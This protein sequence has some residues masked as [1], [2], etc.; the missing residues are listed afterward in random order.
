MP[1]SIERSVLFCVDDKSKVDIGEPGSAV[2]TGVRGKKSIVPVS[3]T[4]SAL[5]HDMQSKLSLTP[6]VALKVG[7]PE[8][9]EESFYRGNVTVKYKDSVFQPSTPFRHAVEMEQILTKG[10]A[11]DAVPPIL[12][13]FSD[14]GPDHRITYHSVKLALIVLFKK[15]NLDM[16]IAGRSAPG[17][18]WLNPA[19]RIMSILNLALQNAAL[20]RAECRPEFE[21]TLNGA[22]SMA[23]IRKNAERV[24][25]LKA[26]WVQSASPVIELLEE[27]TNRLSLQSKRFECQPA[28][29]DDEVKQFEE[30][31][32]ALIDEDITLGQY[33]EKNVKAKAAY[34]QFLADHCR[35]RH[36][37]FQ[38]RKCGNEACCR[39]PQ[40]YK[41]G[42]AICT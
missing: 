13:I 22:N 29:S 24:E 11:N 25:G 18:S 1:L 36:Y 9:I 6:S 2:S 32:L 42:P 10:G 12:M 15:L 35:Q 34:Q 8:S 26:A 30:Q 3:S 40:S 5:D 38:I 31:V 21:T 37:L 39:P 14:G 27:R 16:L 33:Q 28:A 41:W 20:I 23:D 19:E 4:L 7:V 17:H